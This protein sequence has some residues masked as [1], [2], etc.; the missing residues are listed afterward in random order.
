MSLTAPRWILFGVLC[1]SVAWGGETHNYPECDRQP[2][3]T[4]VQAAKGAF[5]AGSASFKE[6]DY[7]RAILYWEDAHRRDCTATLLL[8][9]LGGA[10]EGKGDLDQ[11][12]VALRA[13]LD[14]TPDAVDRPLI[15]RRI[16][17]FEEKL[18]EQ[19]K[20][21][22]KEK[23]RAAARSAPAAKRPS[24]EPGPRQPTEA[25][26]QPGHVNPEFPLSVAGLGVVA[27]VVGAI[28]YFP[29]R[30]DVDH[31][32]KVCPN[33]QCTD[34]SDTDP[35]N[36]A[37]TSVIL[38]GS[39]AI[40]GLVVAAAGTGWYFYNE[41]LASPSTAKAAERLPVSPWWSPGQAGVS[42][43]GRF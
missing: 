18:A 34:P 17:V 4:D 22:E 35:A 23:K 7:D 19:R 6:A 1:A 38:G 42:W 15:Q 43:Q 40:G 33:R 27:A 25:A 2:S 36:E 32:E 14:R 12:I 41:S 3:P 20:E 9:H 16:E 10:Y 8:Y 5:Q 13:Y 37:R 24:A 30:S 21:A 31:Y 29:A 11:A 39:L 28:L 26:A